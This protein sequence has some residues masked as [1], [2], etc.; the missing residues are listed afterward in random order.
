MLCRATEWVILSGDLSGLSNIF[1]WRDGTGDPAQAVIRPVGPGETEDALHLLLGQHGRRAEA[2]S[3]ADFIAFARHR[4]IDLRQIHVATTGTKL[5]AACLP[6]HSP[7][8]TVLMMSS[9]TGSSRTMPSIISLCIDA[10]CR[11]LDP[12]AVQMVQLL[13][14]PTDTRVADAMREIG[15][16]D[17]ADLIYLQRTLSRAPAEPPVPEGCRLLNYSPETHS[18]FARGI[19]ASYEQ[20]LDC[21]VLH[22]RRDIQDVIEGHKASGEFDPRLWFCLVEHEIE[23][24]VL[25]LAPLPGHMTMELVYIGLAPHARGRGIGDFFL[26]LA[27]HRTATADLRMLTL[28]VDQVNAPAL[29]LYHRHGLAEVH[30]RLAMIR[31]LQ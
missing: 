25:L 2:A 3:V 17:L 14:E 30:R 31:S 27:L 7:G 22:G 16:V 20:S 21:A 26:K 24:G 19:L 15:F 9:S 4:N 18:H 10:G 5:L 11:S 6:V 1:R 29:H 23:L 13:L 28:A 12:A 8:R